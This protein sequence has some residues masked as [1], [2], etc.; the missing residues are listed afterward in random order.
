MSWGIVTRE[1]LETNL[2]DFQTLSSD[3]GMKSCE[4]VL[5]NTSK[6]WKQ[7]GCFNATK[8]EYTWVTRCLVDLDDRSI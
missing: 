8:N 5:V 7:S 3:C 6:Y 1:S 4:L 2:Q